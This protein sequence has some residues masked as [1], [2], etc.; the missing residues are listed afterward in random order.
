ME[1]RLCSDRPLGLIF[2][3]VD[4][5]KNYPS[6]TPA[7]ESWEH[8]EMVFSPVTGNMPTCASSD[9]GPKRGQTDDERSHERTLG[10]LFNTGKENLVEDVETTEPSK[11]R[12]R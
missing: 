5:C 10:K 3:L 8:S 6:V 9:K 4:A 2:T 7:V 1:L 12:P 11:S